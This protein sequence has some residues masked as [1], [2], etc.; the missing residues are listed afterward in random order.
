MPFT[1]VEMFPSESPPLRDALDF[2]SES[3]AESRGAIHTRPEVAN[4]ILDLVGWSEPN[5]LKSQR[6]L[7]PSC[8]EGDFLIPAVERLLAAATAS[9]L[10]IASSIVAVEVNAAALAVCRQRLA[11]LLSSRGWSTAATEQLLDTWLVHADFLTLPLER[12]FTHVIGNPP[13]IRLEALPKEL[14]ELYRSRWASLFDRADL[15]VA[16][17]EKALGLLR[18]E[19]RLGFICAD[20]WMK[21]RYGGPLR[22]II[23]DHFHLDAYVDLTGC[24]AFFT[25]VDA[26]PAITI[27]RR[28]RG[29]LTYT[30]FRPEISSSVLAP[31]AA[32]LQGCAYHPAVSARHNVIKNRDPWIFDEFGHME[33]I[34]R[35][36]TTLPLIEQVGIKIG[37]GVATGADAVF[38]GSD[39]DVEDSR[40]LPLVTTRD[41]RGEHIEWRGKWVL[42]PF[43]E[44]G[45]LV[46]LKAYPRFAAYL[47]LHRERIAARNV[48]KRSGQG[49][50]R[51]IDRIQPKLTHTPKLLIPDIKG[52]A[53][54]V[55]D[56]GKFYPHHNLY[57]FTSESWE[58]AALRTV[59]SSRIGLAFVSAYSPRMRGGNLRFQAQY[60]RRIRLPAWANVS[61]SLRRRL[62]E[63]TTTPDA[64]EAVRELYGLDREAWESL[65]DLKVA[66][67]QTISA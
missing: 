47:E 41:I 38:I 58:L 30:A 22:Q 27:F 23:A 48:A 29:S 51:T 53:H 61:S 40:K 54:V 35:L 26:Y 57:Y 32:A 12:D 8:G 25:E 16:F 62:S 55:F 17:F 45:Q 2:F 33:I 59:L 14:L 21:N 43:E 6:L 67:I 10:S 3:D 44:N 37:I 64:T 11:G 31:I 19:A 5:A 1:Q 46:D 9:D 15:Y 18:P 7:E 20:R 36:E 66:A 42:N 34:R 28:G 13:Y 56:A 52:K 49:W 4:F 50:F 65:G 24:P 39:L 63:A 60:L